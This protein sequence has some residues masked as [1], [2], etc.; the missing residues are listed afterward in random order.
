VTFPCPQC[1]AQVRLQETTGFVRC[2]FCGTSLALELSGIR[3]HYVYRPRLR[4]ADVLPL[5]R[6]F[7]DAQGLPAARLSGPPRLTYYPF[8]RYAADGRARLVPAW[9]T[10]DSRWRDVAA[11]DAEQALFD[12]ELV[13]DARLVEA[14]V[15]EPAARQVATATS[16]GELVHIAFY[17]VRAQ[18]GA[19]G[20]DAAVDA[21][22]GGVVAGE[23]PQVGRR[24]RGPEGW[25]PA[26]AFLLMLAA[27]A[28]LPVWWLA[29]A[30]ILP[31][32]IALRWALKYPDQPVSRRAAETRR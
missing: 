22:A 11:P 30:A 8:W 21:C 23:V 13:G 20:L 26:A 1:G 14:A 28:W 3:P 12:P 10:I 7:C 19:T 5:L 27:G 25:V 32:A 29:A 9:P 18:V 4:A 2:P 17:E 6:R 16:A 15:E 24:G 31:I